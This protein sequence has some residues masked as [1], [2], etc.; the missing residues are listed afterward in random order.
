MPGEQIGM[1][2][3]YSGPRK[4]IDKLFQKNRDLLG[5]PEYSGVPKLGTPGGEQETRVYSEEGV[6]L[7]LMASRQPK[8]REFQMAVARLLRQLR[9]A[10]L[11]GMEGALAERDQKLVQIEKAL[12]PE[13]KEIYDEYLEASY[14]AR[15]AQ[16]ASTVKLSRTTRRTETELERRTFN[17]EHSTVEATTLCLCMW[18]S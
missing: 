3:G 1:L 18:N 6:Y 4:A 11:S 14:Q 8:A 12:A 5:R 17:I 13:R 15:K 10:D 16:R 2:L 9:R 7:L